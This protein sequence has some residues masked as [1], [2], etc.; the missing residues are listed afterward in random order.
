MKINETGR[1]G[2]INSYQRNIEA[3]RQNEDKKS[4]RK[5]EVTISAEAMEM[6]QATERSSN[7]E[8]AGQIQDLKQQV[9]SGTYQ[10]DSSKLAE[11]LLPYFK[12]NSEN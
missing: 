9:T 1:V 7:S 10:V 3:G 11:K 5:D 4:R 6:L 8:R 12:Q 2:A